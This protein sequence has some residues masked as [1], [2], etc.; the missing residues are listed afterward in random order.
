MFALGG[1]A[2]TLGAFAGEESDSNTTGP[3]LIFGRRARIWKSVRTT[4]PLT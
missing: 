1:L 4:L 3:A 2:R